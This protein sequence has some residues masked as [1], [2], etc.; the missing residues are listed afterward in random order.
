MHNVSLTLIDHT[1]WVTLPHN[2]ADN[3]DD[4][5]ARDPVRSISEVG[6]FAIDQPALM[7]VALTSSNTGHVG[8][9]VSDVAS[10]WHWH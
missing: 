8:R 4:G 6:K 7:S 10:L 1:A 9:S 3:N 5:K 2:H